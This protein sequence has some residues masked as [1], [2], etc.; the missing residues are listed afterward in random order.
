VCPQCAAEGHADPQPI[1]NFYVYR[2]REYK[3]ETAWYR[4]KNNQRRSQLCRR[5]DQ[6]A[7][8]ER[9]RQRLDPDSDRYD[10]ELH[11]RVKEQKRNYAADKLRPEGERYDPE[12][13]ERQKASKRSSAAKARRQ[14]E[15][16][17]TE[18]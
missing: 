17:Q 18:H 16:D 14:A 10:P 8:A 1:D 2:A 15:R 12:L 9:L 11:E 5:H 6:L 3:T 13:H 7:A 4:Y